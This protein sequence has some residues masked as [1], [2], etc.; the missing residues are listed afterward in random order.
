MAGGHTVGLALGKVW[1]LPVAWGTP[2][3]CLSVGSILNLVLAHKENKFCLIF[4]CVSRFFPS[5][6]L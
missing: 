3:T 5:P 6:Q 4:A 2:G 1:L